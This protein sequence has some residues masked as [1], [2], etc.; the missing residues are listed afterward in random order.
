MITARVRLG[1]GSQWLASG[2]SAAASPA[3]LP[4]C[5]PAR[6]PLC[7]TFRCVSAMDLLRQSGVIATASTPLAMIEHACSYGAC[8]TSSLR[9]LSGWS[10]GEPRGASRPTPTIRVVTKRTFAFRKHHSLDDRTQANACTKQT[11]QRS[12]RGRRSNSTN[13]SE[14]P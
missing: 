9:L 2:D 12:R 14:R 8:R 7:R 6:G 13:V 3:R 11:H 10:V 5:P 1:H 4:A